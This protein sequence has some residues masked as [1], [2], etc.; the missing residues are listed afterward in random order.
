MTRG[1]SPGDDV[2]LGGSMYDNYWFETKG[3]VALYGYH[4]GNA[5]PNLRFSTIFY[6]G[7]TPYLS[8][9]PFGDVI[10]DTQLRDANDFV[11]MER[12]LCASLYEDCNSPH[13]TF[14]S[15]DNACPN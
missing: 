15:G 4:P 11:V 2:W 10:V 3:G 12:T 5:E 8:F 9:R 7:K 13:C 6:D 14:G 1:A